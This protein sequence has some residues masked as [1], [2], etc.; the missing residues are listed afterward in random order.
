[1]SMVQYGGIS[2]DQ[3]TTVTKKPVTPSNDENDGQEVSSDAESSGS[4]VVLGS[5]EQSE[6]KEEEDEEGEDETTDPVVTR[7]VNLDLD[8]PRYIDEQESSDEER[9]LN[10]QLQELI[11]EDV[12]YICVCVV[13]PYGPIDRKSYAID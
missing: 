10:E 6:S 2:Q 1:M 5:T 3:A 7:F 12:R 11:E 13:F 4:S 9:I 8:R